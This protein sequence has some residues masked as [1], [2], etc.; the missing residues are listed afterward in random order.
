M[1]GRHNELDAG[2]I[3]FVVC[4]N[5]TLDSA[6]AARII[7]SALRGRPALAPSAVSRAQTKLA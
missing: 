4:D 7:F 3:L 2:E 1:L 6:T 5:D